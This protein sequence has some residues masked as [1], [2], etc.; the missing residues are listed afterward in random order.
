MSYVNE[1]DS[2]KA[3]A[4]LKTWVKHNPKFHGLEIQLDEYSDGSLM[5]E[6]MQLMLQAERFEAGDPDV[7]VV[8]GVLYNVTK[9]FDAA[10]SS[11]RRALSTYPDDYA[12][13]NKLGATLANSNRAE[14]AIPAYYR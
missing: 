9:D 3:L 2:H 12:L 5:D 7:Q 6:V 4:T 10:A 14:E 8:L 13:W 1:L 11:F